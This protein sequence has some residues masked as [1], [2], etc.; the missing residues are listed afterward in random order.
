MKISLLY[1][2]GFMSK[3]VDKYIKSN[4]LF[5]QCIK[6]QF[7]GDFQIEHMRFYYMALDEFIEEAK[8]HYS[9][10]SLDLSTAVSLFNADIVVQEELAQY[11]N[12]KNEE[13]SYKRL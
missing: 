7:D 1:I 9:N 2:G 12:S 5:R 8:N 11:N 4:E 10:D 6:D 13:Q 3:I